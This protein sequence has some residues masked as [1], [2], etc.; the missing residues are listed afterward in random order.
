MWS[1]ASVLALGAAIVALTAAVWVDHGALAAHV[2]NPVERWVVGQR[3]PGATS[4]FRA[5]TNLGAPGF[6][7]AGGLLLAGVALVRSVP[8][9]VV[10]AAVT[11][12]RPLVSRGVKALVDRPRPR[13]SELVTASD[14]SYPS[15]HVLAAT[16]CWLALP[17]LV[18]LWFGMRAA[19]LS[20]ALGAAVVIVVMASRVYLGV[21]WFTDLLGGLLLGLLLLVPVYAVLRL[22]R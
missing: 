1:R 22:N 2:D 3:S 8:V 5:A 4:F 16:V 9:A 7:F 17:A 21:H 14:A 11:L 6:M 13:L 15:G 20:A 18:A 12:L 10:V 19:R